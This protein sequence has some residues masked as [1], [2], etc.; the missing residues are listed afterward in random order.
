MLQQNQG[1]RPNNSDRFGSL[2]KK[3]NRGLGCRVGFTFCRLEP[4]PAAAV[5]PR[6]PCWA[7]DAAADEARVTLAPVSPRGPPKFS[8]PC[9][10]GSL[11]GSGTAG[12]AGGGGGRIPANRLAVGTRGGGGGGLM[13]CVIGVVPGTGGDPA[14]GAALKGAVEGSGA[15]S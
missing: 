1:H 5:V 6:M 3:L 15:C 14:A 2:G 10:R 8:P 9:G 13:G 4:A 7:A 12:G 11:G